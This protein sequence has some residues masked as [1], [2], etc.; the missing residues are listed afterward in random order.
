MPTAARATLASQPSQPTARNRP[1]CKLG[2]FKEF[3]F[4]WIQICSKFSQQGFHFNTWGGYGLVWPL[5]GAISNCISVKRGSDLT[6][7]FCLVALNTQKNHILGNFSF[8]QYRVCGQEI[9]LYHGIKG[10]VKK[11]KIKFR[12]L[13]FPHQKKKT[14]IIIIL[15][16]RLFQA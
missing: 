3:D 4:Q 7:P 9:G 16:F 11:Y 13:S 5:C 10:A 6:K 12:I 8:S 1:D 15:G 14:K 2:L